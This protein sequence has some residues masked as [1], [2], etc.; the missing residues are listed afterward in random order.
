MNWKEEEGATLVLRVKRVLPVIRLGPV[1]V[2]HPSTDAPNRMS[3]PPRPRTTNARLALCKESDRREAGWIE[4][5]STCAAHCC[6]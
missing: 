5:G 1:L 6:L 3:R 4:A 2:P